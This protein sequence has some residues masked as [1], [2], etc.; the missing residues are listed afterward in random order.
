MCLELLLKLFTP[1]QL[2][3]P[4]IKPD[5]SKTVAN[6]DLVAV[7]D[8]WFHDYKVP[9][10]NY[11]HWR[12]SIKIEMFDN[13]PQWVYDKWPGQQYFL[14]MAAALTYDDTDG[15]HLLIKAPFLNTGVMAH[16]QAHNSYAL[17]TPEQKAQFAVDYKPLKVTDKLMKAVFPK[18][19]TT[20]DDVESHAELYRYLGNQMP[21]SL[22]QYYP[23]LI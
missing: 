12:N 5:Y 17:L 8:Q 7:F 19:A 2:P 14:D 6:S 21:E 1:V 23:K 4:P 16:E 15:R 22:K 10:E 13:W 11:N 3:Y 20:T 18:V 9:F